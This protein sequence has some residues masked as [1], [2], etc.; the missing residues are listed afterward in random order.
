LMEQRE[1]VERALAAIEEKQA[2]L[3]A[4]RESLVAARDAAFAAIDATVAE[5]T[6]ERAAIAGELPGDLLALYDKV[7]AAN[8]GVGAAALRQRRCEGCR[9]E[10]A[11]TELINARTAAADAVLRCE[12]CRRILVRTADSGL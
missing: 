8:G 1:G 6:A 11:G 2:A 12:N 5:R 10:L 4:R 9:I 3:S 7:R